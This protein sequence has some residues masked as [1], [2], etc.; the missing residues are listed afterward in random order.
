MRRKRTLERIESG[1]DLV[2]DER[3]LSSGHGGNMMGEE[4]QQAAC[5][6]VLHRSVLC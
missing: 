1:V 2:A 4:S 3:Q 5:R 6:A